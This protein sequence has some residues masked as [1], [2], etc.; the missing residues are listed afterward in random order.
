MA[1]VTMVK[2]VFFVDVLTDCFI[3]EAIGNAG[4]K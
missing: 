4:K 1:D 2:K 3:T